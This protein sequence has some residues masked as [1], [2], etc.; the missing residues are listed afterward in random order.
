MHPRSSTRYRHDLL[1]VCRV[2]VCVT[3][4]DVL[5]RWG[6]MPREMS[7]GDVGPSKPAVVRVSDTIAAI[8]EAVWDAVANPDPARYN[9]FV[10]HAFLNALEQSGSV[11]TKTGWLPRHLAL[12]PK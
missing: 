1:P 3:T 7:N 2:Q 5:D 4:T 10:A 6:E 8:P 12:H 11:G 9:P